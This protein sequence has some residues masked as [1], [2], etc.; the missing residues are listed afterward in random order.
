MVSTLRQAQVDL[1]QR[2][3]MKSVFESIPLNDPLYD[4]TILGVLQMK[5]RQVR[6]QVSFECL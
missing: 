2:P 3:D 1:D 5:P 6:P 4:A